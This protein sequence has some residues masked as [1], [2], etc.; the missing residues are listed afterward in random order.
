MNLNE[1][2][3]T[4]QPWEK[5]NGLKSIATELSKRAQ[6]VD[7]ATIIGDAQVILL[8][9][10]HYNEAV[11]EHIAQNAA[12]FRGHGITHYGIEASSHI[13]PLLDELNAGQTVNFSGVKLGPVAGNYEVAVRAMAQSGIHVTTIDVDRRQ[14]FPSK[15]I[16]ES[17]LMHRVAETLGQN[18]NNRLA[19]LIGQEHIV[20]YVYPKLDAR[21][22]GQLLAEARIK[23][24]TA[25]YAGGGNWKA[26]HAE[27]TTLRD[28]IRAANLNGK[29]FMIDLRGQEIWRSEKMFRY[30]ADFIVHLRE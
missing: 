13:Q 25:R 1:E 28:A 10:G 15:S 11:R 23:T 17:H 8:G 14:N 30:E 9:E 24:H 5:W 19:V 4:G 22:L 7:F 3:F 18:E 16:R 29:E 12:I 26:G 21:E 20:T 6:P 27:D 2:Q